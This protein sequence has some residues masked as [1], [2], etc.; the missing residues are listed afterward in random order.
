M[1][2]GCVG[3]TFAVRQLQGD[4]GPNI[5]A[6]RLETAVVLLAGLV[7][8]AAVRRW[9]G[10]RT[11]REAAKHSVTLVQKWCRTAGVSGGA[12]REAMGPHSVPSVPSIP[13]IPSI[14]SVHSI[15]AVPDYDVV[16]MP[17]DW[18][19]V[20]SADGR[21][22]SASQVT[23][24]DRGVST[25]PLSLDLGRYLD[26]DLNVPPGV[27]QHAGSAERVWGNDAVV[28][29]LEMARLE[30]TEATEATALLS[31]VLAATPDFTFV[32]DLGSGAVVY[33]PPGKDVVGIRSE[34]LIGYGAGVIA[35]LV[36]PED[37]GRLRAANV[38][39]ADLVDGQV[40]QIRYRMRHTDGSWH[41]LSRRVTP[42]HRDANGH[43]IEVLGVVRDVTDIVE[44][45][46]VLQNSALHDPLTGLPNR[47]LLMDR[48][49]EA[50]ARAAQTGREAAVLFCDLDGFKRVN[51]TAGHAAGDAVLIETTRRMRAVLREQDTIARVG[52]DEFVVIVE[53]WKRE[54]GDAPQNRSLSGTNDGSVN[55][56][57][58]GPVGKV[59]HVEPVDDRELAIQVAERLTVALR[60]PVRVDGV[61]H[62]VTASIGITYAGIAAVKAD[63]VLRDA[64][65]AMYHAKHGGKDRYEVFEHGLRTALA[66]RGRVEQLLRRAVAPATV[67]APGGA[68]TLVAAYQPVVDAATGDLVG[69]EALARLTD[70][71]GGIIP[72]D[73]FIPVAE[74]NALIRPLGMLMLDMACAQLAMWRATVPGMAHVTMAVNVSALQAQHASLVDDVRVT[75]RAHGLTANDLVLELTESSLLEA[76]P[77]ALT[78]LKTLRQYGVG[79]TIDDFGTGYASLSYLVTLPVSAVKVDRSF[80]AG[81]PHDPTCRTIVR[82]VI[83]LA[84]ELH[85]TCIVEGVETEAQRSA[86]PTGV[87]LQGWL[88]GRPALEPDLTSLLA[89]KAR[90]WRS[91]EHQH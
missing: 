89:G 62:V 72:P 88:T 20:M 63:D 14:P 25:L 32:T 76:G 39:A 73:V 80:T 84:A 15:R 51:D 68:P 52:G 65:A 64:D 58:V 13:S 49:E 37:Q 47:A 2:A 3:V 38:T 82:A 90:P 27:G 31:A 77:S 45:E 48:L 42:F 22:A 46:A 40:L 85:L 9:A 75:L 34:V 59:R 83:G 16:A 29:D 79:I 67:P 57:H 12:Q 11:R 44:A 8:V 33:A 91:P 1:V 28:T 43:V 18:R 56:T 70:G 21:W 36:H 61:E 4:T 71:Q 50:L 78:T 54:P 7:G 66:E 10:K 19:S 5:T 24:P 30:A 87:Q 53:P 6:V 60:Q 35:T 23:R 55:K 81:L 74:S 41:W 69:F 86:L 26:P 17:R